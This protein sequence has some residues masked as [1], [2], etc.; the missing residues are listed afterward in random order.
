[1]L[2]KRH[3]SLHVLGAASAR[4]R[5][6][7][8][9]PEVVQRS[10]QRLLDTLGCL[11]AGYDIGI[12]DEIRSY[13]E[14]Q[15]G[16]AQATLLPGGQ[17]TTPAL[18]AL[19]HASYI[20]GLELSDAAPR[21]TVHPGCEIVSA[22]IAIAEHRKLGGAA[23][24]PAIVAGYEVEI[25]FGR[26]LHPGAFY[27]GWST[28]GLLGCIGPAVTAGHLLGL[29]A[30]QMD[31]AIGIVLQLSPCATGRANQS[32]SFRWLI[33]GHG[34]ATGILAAEMAARGITG[35]R[36]VENGWLALLSDEIHPH[37][38]IEGI[39]ANGEFSQW[40][41]LSGIITKYYATVGPIAAAIETT[42]NLVNSN[43][44]HGDDVEDI[45]IECM[46]RTAIFKNPHPDNELAGHGSMPYCVAVAIQ[47][48]DPAS[49]LGPAFLPAM[50]QDKAIHRLSDKVRITENEDYERQYPAR[51]LVRVTIR[52]KDGREHSLETDRSD[53]HRYLYPTDADIEGKF[54]LIADPVL[55][56]A[57]SQK[58]IEGIRSIETASTI[59]HVIAAMRSAGRS[60]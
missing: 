49:L 39:E 24:L 47:T 32:G 56:E 51:S 16:A 59:D 6:D 42:F 29:S 25:R 37:C 10:K 48:R 17:R 19:A 45:H 11:I 41:L 27:K 36:D 13:V 55:G 44:I 23:L 14:S 34:C 22:A 58:I 50:L 7:N 21:G 38:L 60:S 9:P 35:P 26:A 53:I 31:N 33:G 57:A 20:Y 30:E 8:L 52:L 2:E 15:G 4:L 46:R 1:M 18:A 43:D 12:S 28:T 40:E 3:D 5:L 54:R